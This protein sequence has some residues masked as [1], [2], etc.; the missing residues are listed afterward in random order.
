M[1]KPMA[2][3]W[4]LGYSVGMAEKP[5]KS[6]KSIEEIAAK[7]GRYPVE[8]YQFVGMGLGYTTK[9][10]KGEA[11]GPEVARHVTG[12]ELSE[13]L[14]EL[15]L[16]QWGRLAKTVLAKWNIHS[17][18]DFG[19]IVFTLVSHQWMSKTENDRQEDFH[20]VFDFETAFVEEYR[21]EYQI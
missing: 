12:Q 3:A 15:A 9:R 16:K 20:A 13:G 8:A 17:T 14:R 21:I 11:T 6:T 1:T 7:D 10:L 2:R 4:G 18:D 19:R 5:R